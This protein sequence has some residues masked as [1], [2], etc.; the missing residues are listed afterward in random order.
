MTTKTLPS[1]AAV[2]PGQA[3]ADVLDRAAAHLDPPF[4]V[5]DLGALR[6]NA[7][8]L[9]VRASGKPIRVASKSVRCRWVIDEVL[10]VPG[11]AGVLA[12]TLPEALWLAETVDDVVV[13]YPTADRSALKNLAADERLAARVTLMVDSI[14]SLDFL[15]VHLPPAAA[16]VRICLELDA[17]LRLGRLHLGARR[18][19]THDAGA[20]GALAGEVARDARFR[21]VGVMG[22]EGQIA[23]LGDDGPDRLRRLPTRLVQAASAWELAR[24]RAAAVAAVRSVADLEFVN[25]GGTGSIERTVS[26]DAVTEVAAG[27]GLY[28][29]TLFDNYRAFQ[30]APA[31]YFATAVVRRP[32]PGMVTVQGGGWIASG[33]PGADRQPVPVWP[34]GLSLL[35]AEGAGEAQ[36][37]LAGGAVADGLALG[38][39]VWWRH[40]K[41]GELCERVASLALVADGNVVGTVPT[42]RGEGHAFL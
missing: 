32:A 12:L 42:Y 25:G 39:R 26:E 41:A 30:P 28:G 19:P 6:A 24:R 38:D 18:S 3:A 21:L 14:E 10:R 7:D 29:P 9:V 31:A 40:A 8:D 4:A 20:L 36:T 37:P 13:G 11:Y 1:L 34:E 35:P 22:Y 33:P 17:A 27:S 15:R 23:G 16:P 2:R 5:L